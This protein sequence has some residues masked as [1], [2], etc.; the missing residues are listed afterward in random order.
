MLNAMGIL[1]NNDYF[2]FQQKLPPAPER[3][4]VGDPTTTSR[5]KEIP[6]FQTLYNE[7]GQ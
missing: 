5:T 3:F 1:N 4:G 7:T 2:Q 6:Y